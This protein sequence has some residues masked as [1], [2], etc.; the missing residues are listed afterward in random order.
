MKP[1]RITTLAMTILLAI[2][3]A[4]A[5]MFNPVSWTTRIEMTG[6]ETGKIVFSAK[7]EQGWHVYSN[8]IDPEI[9]PTPLSL[10]L[11]HI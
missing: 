10:S 2:L 8:D 5:Q 7:I 4:L 3:P 1:Q 9:G 6:D 11:I